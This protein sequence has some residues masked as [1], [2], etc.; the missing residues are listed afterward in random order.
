MAWSLNGVLATV[1]NTV[2]EFTEFLETA[3]AYKYGYYDGEFYQ[4]PQSG[5]PLY[6]FKDKTG[7]R[8]FHFPDFK[9]E[10]LKQYSKCW[11]ASKSRLVD[12][13]GIS[14]PLKLSTMLEYTLASHNLG[15]L[16][17]CELAIYK[18]DIYAIREGHLKDYIK[19]FV[20]GYMNNHIKRDINGEVA[21]EKWYATFTSIMFGISD[22]YKET[23]KAKTKKAVMQ[24]LFNPFFL[25]KMFLFEH[26]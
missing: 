17:G 2:T 11:E 12:S 23:N 1:K 4:P 20:Y 13:N 21:D 15:Y 14:F 8:F 24:K 22:G 3:T 10:D 18:N 19:G 7:G 26:M 5:P 9:K 6:V 16:T 25:L